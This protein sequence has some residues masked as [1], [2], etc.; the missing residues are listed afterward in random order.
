MTAT[1]STRRP[2]TG[3]RFEVWASV[4]TVFLLAGF[5]VFRRIYAASALAEVAIP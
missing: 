3:A 1:E 4:S 2:S 5:W